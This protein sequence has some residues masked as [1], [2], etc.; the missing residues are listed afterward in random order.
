MAGS[1]LSRWRAATCRRSRR[2]PGA[3][4]ARRAKSKARRGEPRPGRAV[5]G[6]RPK[7]GRTRRHSE[8][9]ARAPEPRAWPGTSTRRSTGSIDRRSAFGPASA[10][11]RGHRTPLDRWH[12]R[13]PPNRR[14]VRARSG[15]RHAGIDARARRAPRSDRPP[16]AG[17]AQIVGAR[18]PS[19]RMRKRPVGAAYRI[20]L[21]IPMPSISSRSG[22]RRPSRNTSIRSAISSALRRL[23][24]GSSSRPRV[25]GATSPAATTYAL[26]RGPQIWT[27]DGS[28]HVAGS[29]PETRAWIDSR[30]ARGML[31]CRPAEAAARS[32]AAPGGSRSSSA[33]TRR[34][35]ARICSRVRLRAG[36][37]RPDESLAR[38]SMK[39]GGFAGLRCGDF[40][41]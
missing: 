33:P 27:S 22:I 11:P 39:P 10:R 31:S 6:R 28:S 9:G 26:N 23:D 24:A 37:M 5:R 38:E 30:A 19:Q 12:R 8:A 16:A 41:A 13:C 17:T 35:K 4:P 2:P 15:R 20:A 3:R 25:N 32:E 7:A 18:A 36:G 40:G 29:V 1:T 21:P 14:T 34:R